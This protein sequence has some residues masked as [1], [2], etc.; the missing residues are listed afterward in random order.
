MCECAS[1]RFA[2]IGVPIWRVG[3]DQHDGGVWNLCGVG[4]AC[5]RC[6]TSC[7][8]IAVAVEHLRLVPRHRWHVLQERVE[9]ARQAHLVRWLMLGAL[10]MLHSL[11]LAC[12]ISSHEPAHVCYLFDISPDFIYLIFH[13][14]NFQIKSV[15]FVLF[16]SL[17]AVPHLFM[18]SGLGGG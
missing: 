10:R 9:P 12:C 8:A 17:L 4:V 18:V 16:C 1:P 5:R 13:S 3:I 14:K 11:T 2:R 7:V 6:S 15:N